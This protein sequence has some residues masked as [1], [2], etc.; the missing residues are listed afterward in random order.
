MPP[1]TKTLSPAELAKLEHAFATDPASEAYKPLAEAY[2]GMGRFMEAMVVCKK[3]VKAHPSVADPRVL[4]ARVYAEQGKDKKA[5]EELQGALQVAPADKS[6]LRMMGSL[7]IKGGDAGGKDN[8]LKAFEADPADSETLD[9]M[10][11][12]GV[13][14][15]RPAAPEPPPPPPQPVAAPPVLQ[16]VQ[17]PAGATA[18]SGVQQP[19]TRAPAGQQ[20][21]QAP[22]QAGARPSQPIPRPAVQ[23][24]RDYEEDDDVETS[25]VRARP[26]KKSGG[27]IAFIALFVV[28]FAA[29]AAY[30]GLG[31]YRAKAIKEANA[32]NQA[33]TKELEKDTFKGY[34]EA[35]QKAEVALS[36][37]ASDDTN[38]TAR[39]ILAYAY[40]IRWGE[41]IHDEPNHENARKFLDAGLAAKD[42][43]TNL[44]AAEAMLAFYEGK[45]AAE[46]LGKL[47]ERIKV[48]EKGKLRVG[49]LFMTKGVLQTNA[50]DLESAV[51][52]LRLAKDNMPNDP[53]VFVA[54]GQLM[55]RRGADL[56]AL[57]EFN[58]ALKYSGGR[59]PDALVGTAN[60]ILDQENPGN[61][62]CA[63]AKN[64]KDLAAMTDNASP[65]QLATNAFTK[66]LLISRVS[67]DIPLYTDKAFQK[68]LEDCT[69]VKADEAQAKKDIAAAETEGMSLDRNNPELL[70][71]RG[72]RLA[73]EGK[74]DEAAAEIRKAI[75]A[76]PRASQFHV[77]L[78][79]VLARKEGGEPAAEEALNK[80]L[81]LVPGSPKLLSMLG[82]IQFKQKKFD[83]ARGTLEKALSDPKAKNPEARHLLGKLYRDN[84]D[85]VK[86]VDN[87][88]RASEEYY[89][90][91]AM[92]S[93]V[94]DD[95]AQTYEL[96]A[97]R[98]NALST[99]EKAL[100]ADKDNALPYCHYARLLSKDAKEKEKAKKIAEAFLKMAPNDPCAAEMRGL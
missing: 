3:G 48:A 73:Y 57:A 98:D 90:D 5:I 89:N 23:A 17:S 14:V 78:A 15:P 24:R 40:T 19:V 86:S 11:K 76:N 68:T 7:Q 97:E 53:R 52:S 62:Y 22:R 39:G 91:R 8:L 60:L 21:R 74:L 28:L 10:Q 20:P 63:A 35:I 25:D 75:E 64:I 43:S 96:K 93:V 49:R 4:L 26:Q 99:Y 31:Q 56:D 100:N 88:K 51:D 71:I 77:E 18:T 92:A 69:G 54:M 47:E 84:K 27:A 2:L 34:E 1:A 61:G 9:L 50:G 67:R 81:T 66:A 94:Y 82:Q 85:Y 32:A 46:L 58:L 87:L 45:P 80:A 12:N 16:P 59:S 37:D 36:L 29:A 65:R 72:R 42:V 95:L 55:R 38:R 6:A 30:L 44:Y 13:A 41:H 70:L 33:A 83:A 79:K